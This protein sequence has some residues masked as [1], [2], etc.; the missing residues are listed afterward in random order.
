M[1]K[2]FILNLA[3]ERKLIWRLSSWDLVY[4]EPFMSRLKIRHKNKGYTLRNCPSRLA[5]GGMGEATR[6]GGHRSIRAA[7]AWE[8]MS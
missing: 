2:I 6:H 5:S 3:I 1:R 7:L 8:A 4:A